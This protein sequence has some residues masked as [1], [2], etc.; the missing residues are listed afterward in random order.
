MKRGDIGSLV[1]LKGNSSTKV[2]DAMSFQV[3]DLVFVK[4]SRTLYQ[5]PLIIVDIQRLHDEVD[6]IIL[7][8]Q[9]GNRYAYQKHDLMDNP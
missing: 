9:T 1:Y 5:I 3:K 4:G 2:I 8:P 7:D 6:Y